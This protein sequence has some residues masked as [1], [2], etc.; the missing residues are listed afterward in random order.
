[1]D[2]QAGRSPERTFGGLA[3][4]IGSTLATYVV[5]QVVI[6]LLLTVLYAIGFAVVGLPLWFLLAPLCGMLNLIPHF[7]P[8]VALGTGILVALVG[9]MSVTHMAALVGVYVIVFTLEGYVLTPRI[10]GRRLHLRP[11]YVFAAVLAGGA[12]FGFA[13][14]VLA[15]PALA[16]AA[17]V[18]RHF[19]RLPERPQ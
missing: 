19:R 12:M 1:M 8:L 7:G 18:Y 9:G 11:L 2:E 6:A 15:V 13:G 16:V 4:N 17:V 5:G 10:L 14:L 3:R